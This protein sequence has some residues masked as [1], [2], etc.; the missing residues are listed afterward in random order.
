MIELSIALAKSGQKVIVRPHPSENIT[1]W[2][3]KTKN[4][5]KN[6]K[7]IRS[8]NIIPWLMA[9]KLVIHNGCTTAIEGTFLNKTVISYRPNKNLN[10]ETYLPNAISISI[11]SEEDVVEFI[12]NLILN[13]SNFLSK[14]SINILNNYF[15]FEN[16]KEDTCIKIISIIENLSKKKTYKGNNIKIIS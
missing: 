5:S 7:I 2:K 11:E 1:V 14:N 13:K 9:S 16:D 4:Y 3:N 10:V 15:K 8:G 6:I 12:K